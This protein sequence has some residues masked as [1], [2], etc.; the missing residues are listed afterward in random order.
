M[1]KM[2][3]ARVAAALLLHVIA[4]ASAALSFAHVYGNSMVLQRAPVRAA[5]LMPLP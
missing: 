2:L 1:A 5:C 3:L 4:P